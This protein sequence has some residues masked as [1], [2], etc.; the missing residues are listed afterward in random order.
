MTYRIS[1]VAEMTGIPRNTL[2]AW[3]RRYRLVSPVRHDNGYRSY[4][5]GDI[6]TILRLKNAIGSGLRVGEAVELLR[7]GTTSASARRS[8]EQADPGQVEFGETR[9]SLVTALIEYRRRDID[10]VLQRLLPVPFRVRLTEV[11]FPVMR[12][13]GDLWAA[14]KINIAQEHYAS[15]MIRAHLATVLVSVGVDH[16]AAPHAV[17][18]TFAGDHHE[19]AALALAIELSIA[20]FRV[21]H[22]GPN[23]PAADLVAF[24]RKFRP[25]IACISCILQPTPAAFTSYVAELLTEPGTRWVIGGSV[26]ELPAPAGVE[27]HRHWG[28]FH[29]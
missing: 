14:G 16:P 11:F 23:L 26:P 21:S 10:A 20:G 3:E 29:P 18:T 27:I 5:E 25:D 7:N 2:L 12:E 9:R 4:T 1:T 24:A 17:T 13:V 6:A 28:D 19:I 15:A 22:L 8:I